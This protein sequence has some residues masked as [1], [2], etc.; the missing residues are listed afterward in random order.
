MGVRAD[1]TAC[2][3]SQ[4]PGACVTPVECFLNHHKHVIYIWPSAAVHSRYV[5]VIW[6]HVA[7]SLLSVSARR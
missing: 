1:V 2:C 4:V 5:N 3:T 6:H 7:Q